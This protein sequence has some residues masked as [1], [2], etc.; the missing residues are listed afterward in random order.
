MEKRLLYAVLLSI[1][2]LFAWGYLAPQLFPDLGG[3]PAPEAAIEQPAPDATAE[4][5]ATASE[6]PVDPASTPEAP[7]EPSVAPPQPAIARE[8]VAATA[9]E[10]IVIERPEFRATFTNRG[11]QLI[12]FRLLGHQT[13]EGEQVELVEPRDSSRIDFPFALVSADAEWNRF[14]NSRPWRVERSGEGTDQEIRFSL[15]DPSGALIVKTFQFGADWDFNFEIR[16]ERED[17][18]YRTVIG[19]GVKAGEPGQQ[20]FQFSIDGDGLI[21]NEEGIA[22]ISKNDLEGLAVYPGARLVG[23]HDNYFLTVLRPSVAGDAS[24][25]P[26]D[27]EL[28]AAAEGEQ[29]QRVKEVYAGLNDRGGVVRGKALFLPKEAELLDRFD[30]GDALNLGFFGLIARGLL[31]A[32]KWIN[33]F[34]L[35]YGWSIVLLTIAIKLLLYPLQ[36]KSMVSMKKMQKLQPKMNAIKDKYKKARSDMEQRQKMNQE[37]MQLYQREGINPMSGCFPI[38]LQLPIL[39]AFYSL[40][41]TAIELRGA[42]WILWIHDLSAK[43]PY[44][45]TPI[46]MT[47]TMFIQQL[48]TPMTGDPMQRRIFLLMPLIFGWIFKEFPS[49]LVLY[50]LVQNVLTIIQ[51]MIMNKYWKDHP[52]SLAKARA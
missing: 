1:L 39:W 5:T 38:L 44:Y 46:L 32:L 29:P 23:L 27:L 40:L 13:R 45:I 17:F 6:S 21:G 50:W 18:G 19:P 2:F 49:G 35:N 24:L 9:L 22:K 42:D 14:V 15:T 16:S 28:P 12:S 10:R 36:H 26:V 3:R 20:N 48:L 4:N 47:V 33:T 51:Q 30:L 52:E 25:R 43:D 34:T 31:I 41:S 11:A 7:V 37:M 8:P